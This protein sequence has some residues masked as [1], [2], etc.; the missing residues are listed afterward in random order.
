VQN[1]KERGGKKNQHKPGKKKKINQS[2]G[3]HALLANYFPTLN[4]AMQFIY[5]L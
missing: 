3:Q 5:C 2:S 1:W 4:M